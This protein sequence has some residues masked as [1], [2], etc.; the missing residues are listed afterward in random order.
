MMTVAD[1]GKKRVAAGILG[2]VLGAFGIHK[3]IIGRTAAGLVMLLSSLLSVGML[4]P[5]FFIVG[6][7]EG[8]IYLTKSDE[9]FYEVYL[10]GKRSWF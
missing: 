7:I 10:R 5:I 9:E 2:I 3:F 6:L 4:F 1:A 8:I